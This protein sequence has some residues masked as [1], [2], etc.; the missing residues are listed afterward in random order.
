MISLLGEAAIAIGGSLALSLIVKATIVSI[1]A[2]TAVHMARRV[3]ASVRH[4]LLASGF[5]VLLALPVATLI[6]PALELGVPITS[7]VLVVRNTTPVTVNV[8]LPAVSSRDEAGLSP[9][10]PAHRFLSLGMVL[11]IV[12]IIGVAI[13]LARMMADMLWVRRVRRQARPWSRGQAIVADLPG[14]SSIRRRVRIL[15]DDAAAGPITCGVFRPAIVLPREACDWGAEELRR[16]VIHELEHVRRADLLMLCVARIVCALYWFHPLVW[17]SWRQ[18]RLEA[19]RACDDAVLRGVEP[20][21]YAEQLVTLAE[22]LV[23]RRIES[24]PAMADRTDLAVRI[25]A[26][27]D[28]HQRRGR[29]GFR[30]VSFVSMVA[31]LLLAAGSSLR[32][33][34]RSQSLDS[35]TQARFEAAAFAPAVLYDDG[36]IAPATATATSTAPAPDAMPR[37]A[38]VAVPTMPRR[39]P[40]AAAA[41]PIPAEQQPS[42]PAAPAQQPPIPAAQAPTGNAPARD[43]Y[44]SPGTVTL[45][46]RK[47]TRSQSSADPALERRLEE[48]LKSGSASDRLFLTADTSFNQLNSAEY[49]VPVTVRIAPGRELQAGRGD[50][51]RLEFVG[52]IQDA[53]YGVTLVRMADAFE[54]ALD[55]EARDA[56]ATTPIVYQGAFV[57]L[58]GRYRIRVLV[59]D[60]ATDRIGVI[61]VPFFVPNLNRVKRPQ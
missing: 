32:A 8:V 4:L 24:V 53:P 3:P 42:T 61:D 22:R 60:Q 52:V 1:A 20:V 14:S 13:V 49:R 11:L 44:N 37:S 21:E 36:L 28:S 38:E 5:A 35:A 43:T 25:S 12:W 15:L 33:V 18:L 10:V 40:S 59:R 9:V 41:P 19:E 29:A 56:L 31:F 45:G 6:V 30:V 23:S 47:F 57:L 26:V 55:S 17:M 2:L 50:V 51:L 34:P 58:P 54:L 39:I 46:D 7:P 48:A 27:L 16:A